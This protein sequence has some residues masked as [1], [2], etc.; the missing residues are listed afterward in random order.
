VSAQGGIGWG[1]GLGLL[2]LVALVAGCAPATPPKPPEADLQRPEWKVGDRWVFRRMPTSQLGGVASLVTHEVIE[3]T[4][5]G[6]TMRITRLNEE[7]T[8]YWT[9][10]LHLSRQESRGRLL[11]QYEPAARYFD[12]PLLPGKSWSQ[13]FEYRDGRND[14]RYVNSWRVDTGLARVDMLAGVIGAV[15]VDRFGGA[16]ERLESYWFSP[17]IRYWVRFEDYARHYFE[18]LAEFPPP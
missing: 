14:G 10:D 12:W 2:A 9:R 1:A 7:L 5:D 8:R 18:E 16:G 4:A 6:Y 11:N 3:A 15:R 17:P 13:E